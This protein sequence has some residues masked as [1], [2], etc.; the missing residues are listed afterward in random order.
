MLSFSW[1]VVSSLAGT[2]KRIW[3][4]SKR[5]GSGRLGVLVGLKR[6]SY[7]GLGDSHDSEML[8]DDDTLTCM[9]WRCGPITVITII[10]RKDFLF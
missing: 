7:L 5:E 10:R 6:K 2:G 4:R 3:K 9:N 1:Q 8:G